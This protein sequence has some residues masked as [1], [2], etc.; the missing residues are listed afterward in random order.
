MELDF[1]TTFSELSSFEEEYKRLLEKTLHHLNVGDDV[2]VSVSFVD[3]EFIHQMNRAYRHIDRPTD[4]ISFAFLDGEADPLK[5]LKENTSPICLG[6]IYISVEKAR[7]QAE[8]YGHPL[9]RE[10]QFLF[11]HGL[12]HLLGFD[13]M[14]EEDEKVMFALQDEILK[15]E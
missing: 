12:L 13:H 10:L 7:Q 14:T 9:R 8:E 6:D 4:V 3:N 2:I 1:Q 5:L 11:V 15:K